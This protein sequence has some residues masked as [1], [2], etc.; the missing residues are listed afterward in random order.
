MSTTEYGFEIMAYAD[1]LAADAAGTL[2]ERVLTELGWFAPRS[3]AETPF[4]DSLVI[5]KHSGKGIKLDHEAP[6]FG[7]RDIIGN[8]QPKATGA[9]SPTRAAYAG[10]NLGQYSFI[11]NDV[12]DFEFHLPHD[13]APGTDLYFHV[14]WSHSGTSISG[15]AVFDIYYTYSKGH[16][17]ANYPSEKNLK[18]TYDTTN[19]GTT[20]QYRHRID[21]VAMTGASA[22]A[23]LTDRDDIEVD[24]LI[25]ATLKLT[26]LPTIG[27]GGKLFVHTCDIHY[28][29]TN[30][31]T[32]Q[33]SPGFYS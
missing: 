19:I 3:P 17:Q 24:G 12:C 4:F 10:A 32:K 6:T 1:A 21:E 5:S 33:R 8:V 28:Q 29:S 26:T 23:S 11:A 25:L 20:P 7:W 14:H 18:I 22:T 30:I 16:N 2:D 31:A 13:Y 27:G 9:G 15:N